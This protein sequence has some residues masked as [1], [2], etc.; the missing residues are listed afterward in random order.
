[1]VADPPWIL[2]GVTFTANPGERIAVVGAS[3]AGKTTLL[4][5]LPRLYDVT[6]GQVVVDGVDVRDYS[7]HALRSAIAIVQQDSFVFSGTIRDNIAYGRPE[8]SDEEIEQAA[9]AAHAHEFIAGFEEGYQTLLGERGVNLSGG[10]RQRLSIARAIL[11]NPRI[12]ILDEATSSLDS[13]SESLVQVALDR[14]MSGRTCFIIAHRL[15]TIRN[16]DRILVLEKG[17]VAETGSHGE[18]LALGGVYARFIAR[19]ATP[20]APPA[21]ALE[22][23]VLPTFN[24]SAAE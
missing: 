24:G 2:R 23:H 12:L 16:A 11:K 15:S 13:E 14:L 20:F 5:L 9:I 22:P 1:V 17:H 8:A 7:L 4:A 3:G 10:Q 6:S 21:V 19:Q 18:L